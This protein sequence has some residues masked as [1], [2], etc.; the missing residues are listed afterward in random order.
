MTFLEDSLTRPWRSAK[1]VGAVNES[2]TPQRS[3]ARVYL[4]WEKW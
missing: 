2:S 4:E 1:D 3:R